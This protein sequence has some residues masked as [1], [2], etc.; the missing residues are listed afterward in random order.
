MKKNLIILAVI[1]ISLLVVYFFTSNKGWNTT[2]TKADAFTIKDTA[3]VTKIFMANKN[4]FKVMLERKADMWYVNDM[5][6]DMQKVNMILETLHDIKVLKPVEEGGRNTVIGILASEGIKTEIYSGSKLLK[7]FYVG[8][9]TPDQVGTFMLLDGAEDPLITHIPGFVGYLT[10]RF[11]INPLKLKS[12]LVFNAN[13]S[14]IDT[15]KV[16]YPQSPSLSFY[17][18][19]KKLFNLNQQVMPAD[20]HYINFYLASFSNLYVEGYLTDLT[21]QEVDSVLHAEPYCTISLTLK[22]G[23]KTKLDIYKKSLDV[24]TK[25]RFNPETQEVYT[26]DTEKYFAIINHQPPVALIQ[27]YNFGRIIKNVHEFKVPLAKALH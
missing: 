23:I 11:I 7:T 1:L 10:P 14:D 12:K 15:I 20:T 4:G 2:N 5:P 8:S 25:E 18:T 19:Q 17:L 6:A 13:S 26:N 22:N 24:R 21:K 27:Q 9:E 3:S 16:L